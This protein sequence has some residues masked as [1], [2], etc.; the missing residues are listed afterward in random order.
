MLDI[1]TSGLD[2]RRAAILAIGAVNVEGGQIRLD[3]CWQTLVRPPPEL[4]V[5]P[6]AIQIHQ[7]LRADLEHAPSIEAALPELL[8]RLAGARACGACRRDRCA[9]PRPGTETAVSAST[10]RAGA[11]HGASGDGA[12]SRGALSDRLCRAAYHTF[13]RSALGAGRSA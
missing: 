11:G 6:E 2:A 8:R 10:T 7:L 3:S 9:L 12:C 4:S 5:A 1:E 13:A